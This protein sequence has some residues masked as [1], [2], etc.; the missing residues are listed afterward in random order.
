MPEIPPNPDEALCQAILQKQA[1]SVKAVLAS[2]ADPNKPNQYQMP[3]L[4]LAA[5][6]SNLEIV[7]I[8]LAAGAEINA[9]DNQIYQETPLFKALRSRQ[10]ETTQFLLKQGAKIQLKNAWGDTPLHLAAGLKNISLLEQLL[11]KGS[12]I[13]QPNQ[14]GQTPLHRAA[15]YGDLEMV[16]FLLEKGADPNKTNT[17]DQNALAFAIAARNLPI[18]EYLQPL[19]RPYNNKMRQKCLQMAIEYQFTELVERLLTDEDVHAPL[20]VEHP[21]LLALKNGYGP[22]LAVFKDKGL[23][24]NACNPE[25]EP[26]LLMATDAGWSPSVNWLIQ[27]GANAMARNQEG[28]TA[29]AKAVA[30]GNQLLSETLLKGVKDPDN[31]FA[32]GE[33]GLNL[34]KKSGNPELARLLLMG[35][36]QRNRDSLK[37]WVDQALYLQK[38]LRIDLPMGRSQLPSQFLV[39]L[40]KNIESLGFMLSPALAARILSLSELEFK[41]LYAD[42]LPLL[43]QMVGANKVFNP[44]YPNFP[45]QVMNMPQWEL[46]LNALLHYWGDAVGQRIMPKYEKTE[47]PALQETT[48]FKQIDLGNKS[49]F[50][51]IFT[52]LQMARMA[53]SPDDKKNLEWFI[54]SRGQ[55]IL[56]YLE[57]NLPQRENAALLA[58]ALL[59]HLQQ[60]DLAASYLKNSTDVLRLATAL[61]QGDISLAEKTRFSNFPKALRRFLLAQFERMEDMTEAFQKRPEPFKRLAE[62]LH[63]GEYANRY[64]KTFQAFKA[65]RQGQKLPTFG[66]EVEMAL[67]EQEV[68]TALV[69]LASRPGELARRLD[70]LLRLSKQPQGVLARFETLAKGLPSPLL[71]Q[72]M[73]HFQ[74]RMEPSDLRVFFPKGEVAKLRAIYNFLPE[75]PETVCTRVVNICQAALL[76]IYKQRP[77]LGKVYLDEALQAF[78]VPFALRSAAKALRTVARGSRV[79]LPAGNTIRFFIW[80][81]DGAARTDLD[82]SAL[83]LDSEFKYQSTLAYYNLKELGGCHSGDITSAPEGASEFIDLDMQTFL[84]SGSRYILMVVNSFTEQPYCDLPECFA[85]FMSREF[86][87]SGEIYEPRTVLN[88]F[89]LSANTQIA[90]PLILDLQTKQMIWTDLALKKNPSHANNVHNNRSSLSLLCQAMTELQKPSLYQLL[91][92]NIDARGSRVYNRS[93]AECIFACD[94]GI[95]PWDTD[96]IIS[97][98]L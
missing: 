98:F 66:R 11:K 24:L 90:I 28:Q 48:Q 62:R 1:E 6:Y 91:A 27:H 37:V 64:P 56:P 72:L 75:L 58:A 32:T 59:K 44:M 2:G 15:Q 39:G 23:D 95:T 4:H 84:E 40:Q 97:E 68:E 43:K 16:Q 7:K 80:W 71:L 36:A 13:D 76:Q 79:D 47:R 19:I 60:E 57:A 21:F 67:A 81:K 29:L 86:P 83:A 74:G 14:G 35:G 65:L 18:F 69:L 51:Q 52:R 54:A 53:L 77:P 10:L 78:K 96:Q 42:L 30:K 38:S 93:D 94:Q 50:M 9:I 41:Q 70:H 26:L 73:A 63:P 46:Y 31:C 20:T 55:E 5:S 33:I 3:A 85:G 88:K 34:A 87:N 49:D 8:L 12:P 82:L 89:D 22:V 92:L 61:S 17:F 45:E 25:G